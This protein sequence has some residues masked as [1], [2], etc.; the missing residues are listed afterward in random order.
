M[1]AG[2][3]LEGLILQ[4]LANTFGWYFQ[5]DKVQLTVNGGPYESGHYLFS[6]G[7]YLPYD[8]SGAVAYDNQP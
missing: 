5:T 7:E 1:N 8:T 4:S 2:A 3:A 6:S